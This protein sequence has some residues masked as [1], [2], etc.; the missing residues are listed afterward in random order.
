MI[1][2]TTPP[3]GEPVSPADLKAQLRVTTD[4][5]DDLLA[6]LITA[7][8]ERLEAELGVRVLLTGLRETA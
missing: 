3:A 5:E 8:R 2:V 6:A 7:A 1:I 4:V